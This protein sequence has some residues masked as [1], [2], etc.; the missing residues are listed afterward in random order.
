M[1]EPFRDRGVEPRRVGRPR[2]EERKTSMTT[3]IPTAQADKLAKMALREGVSVSAILRKL[4][5]DAAR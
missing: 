4:V 1:D 5:N 2:C 3:W